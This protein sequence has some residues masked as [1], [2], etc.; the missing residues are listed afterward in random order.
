MSKA[1]IGEQ[2]WAEVTDSRAAEGGPVWSDDSLP[3]ISDENDLE[4]ISLRELA[5][6]LEHNF[7]SRRLRSTVE[8]PISKTR[9]TR[10]RFGLP[11]GFVSR[12][13]RY[14]RSVLIKDNVYRLPNAQEFIPQ[15]PSG[16][17]GA[18]SHKY[19]LL[20]PEQYGKGKRSSVYVRTDGRI[21]DY[22]CDHGDPERELFDTGFTIHD[23]ERTGRYAPRVNLQSSVFRKGKKRKRR[24]KKQ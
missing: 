18:R 10:H 22:A 9:G 1:I 24:G 12:L 14:G 6:E 2:S 21:F 15:P 4:K 13:G 17:L 23:L 7:L 3:P 11:E 20:T 19:G 8:D 5:V 16:T